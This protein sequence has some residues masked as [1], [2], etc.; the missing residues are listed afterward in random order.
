MG[1]CVNAPMVAINDD[2]FED[3]TPKSLAG[4]IAE[5]AAGKSPAPG[6]YA[7]RR[8]CEPAGGP[9]TL[10]DPAL[11]DGSRGKPLGRLPNMPEPAQ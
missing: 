3:L 6:S 1:A 5:F 9:L 2:Y 11:Y 7:G 10:E 4:I 8:G